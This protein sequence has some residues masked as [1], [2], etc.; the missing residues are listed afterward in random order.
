MP[1]T[2]GSAL[3]K[4][5]HDRISRA[6]GTSIVNRVDDLML[7]HAVGCSTSRRSAMYF[8]FLTEC[9][10]PQALTT[11]PIPIHKHSPSMTLLPRPLR[12]THASPPVRPQAAVE[13]DPTTKRRK[14]GAADA[15]PLRD[16]INDAFSEGF[17]CTPDPTVMHE[18][19][20]S[21][22]ARA[23]RDGCRGLAVP[24]VRGR[25]DPAYARAELQRERNP[26][27]Q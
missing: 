20:N 19:V 23:Q 24:R 12:A 9:T 3:R 18:L 2:F 8:T 21:A 7:T 25:D 27:P 22:L 1:N 5:G 15:S 10:D 16:T 11:A 26:R 6:V 17:K 4:T 13:R 14:G